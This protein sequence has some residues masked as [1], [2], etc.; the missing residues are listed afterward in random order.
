MS[1]EE[2]NELNKITDDL[3][4]DI[5]IKKLKD[6]DT[7]DLEMQV[8][9]NIDKARKMRQ[10]LYNK[11]KKN[12][13]NF[14]HIGPQTKEVIQKIN[15]LG[16]G[17]QSKSEPESYD[18]S[19]LESDLDKIYIEYKGEYMLSM[20]QYI[21]YDKFLECHGGNM[22]KAESC[23]YELKDY[24]HNL[25][26]PTNYEN[27]VLFTINS[28][29]MLYQSEDIDD[30]NTIYRNWYDNIIKYF[31]TS[32]QTSQSGQGKKKKKRSKTKKKKGG[33]RSSKKCSSKKQ[34]KKTKKKKSK[35]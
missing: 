26:N 7:T 29:I 25:D 34:I 13:N 32:H 23:L 20:I 10:T 15:R 18:E 14:R 35:K 31:Q 12:I 1:E 27:I 33:N 21:K 5:R 4:I 24:I 22:A 28:I 19:K 6:I 17:V 16:T 9:N 3:L 30:I 8:Q 2:I 11:K